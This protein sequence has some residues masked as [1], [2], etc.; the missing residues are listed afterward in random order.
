MG[1]L[2]NPGCPTWTHADRGINRLKNVSGIYQHLPGARN[3]GLGYLDLTE[4]GYRLRERQDW[5][6]L[7]PPPKVS[8]GSFPA[9]CLVKA[10][11]LPLP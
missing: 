6:R 9:S 3:A 10:M 7:L 1:M 11:G 2:D 8:A 4:K 5:R